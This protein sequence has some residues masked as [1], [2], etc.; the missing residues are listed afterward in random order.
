[1]SD[2]VL[3]LLPLFAV[4]L[5]AFGFLPN[6]WSNSRV[7]GFRQIV[8]F[9]AGLQFVVAASF[10]I[11][12][13]TGRIP[14]IHFAIVRFSSQP[15][16]EISVYYDGVACLMFA[17]VSFVGWVICR[18]SIRYLDGEA[19]QGR[20]FRWTA[21]TIGAVSMMVISGNLLL[22]AAMWVMT[23]L[24]LHQ[25]LMHYGFRSRYSVLI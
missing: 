24:G 15:P 21:V 11:A 18:F 1:M 14:T 2:A 23:S 3:G 13:A 6:S 25:L 4:T 12:H 7:H 20:Y 5:L 10:A 8:T 16:I 17:L 19:T 22:F 9:F